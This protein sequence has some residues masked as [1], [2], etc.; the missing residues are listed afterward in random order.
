MLQDEICRSKEETL[1]KEEHFSQMNGMNHRMRKENRVLQEQLKEMKASLASCTARCESLEKENIELG[2]Q[3]E[4]LR[5]KVSLS[6][7]LDALRAEDFV[8]LLSTN[9]TM[10][11]R[12]RNIVQILNH[13]TSASAGGV[14]LQNSDIT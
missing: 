2:I 5:E 13:T 9:Q 7:E 12:L 1:Q 6:K 8:S 10:S 14:T 3:A 11:D 4:L